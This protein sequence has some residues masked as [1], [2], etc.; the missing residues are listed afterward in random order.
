[1][2]D[3]DFLL[4]VLLAGDVT[5]CSF[6]PPLLPTQCAIMR[7]LALFGACRRRELLR[8]VPCGE[9]T[10][11]QQLCR[12]VSAGLVLRSPVKDGKR[13]VSVYALSPGGRIMVSQWQR[14]VAATLQDLTTKL[15][16]MSGI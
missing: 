13:R 11:S 14:N 10:V 16:K 2:V 9:E 8:V 12:L 15:Q 7:A 6:S 3:D 4:R 1:M 5:D